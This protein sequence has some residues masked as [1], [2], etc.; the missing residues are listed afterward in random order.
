MPTTRNR[1]TP[2]AKTALTS[3]NDA[4][5]ECRDR[6]QHAWR[7]DGDWNL[8]Y[9]S[10][11]RLIEFTRTSTCMRCERAV[12]VQTFDGS[13][14]LVKKTQVRYQPGYLLEPGS[15]RLAREDLLR[16]Q[17]ARMGAVSRRQL[18]VAS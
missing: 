11:G 8:T 16:E 3:M 17:L 10:R 2:D 4:V 7:Y 13:F 15:G 5:L 12:Q 1:K 18:R 14:R 9:S 6:H